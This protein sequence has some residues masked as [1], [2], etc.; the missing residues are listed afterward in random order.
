MHHLIGIS[1]MMDA[2]E[3]VP[4]LGLG[5]VST[6]TK[7]INK[8]KKYIVSCFEGW[9]KQMFLNHNLISRIPQTVR[10]LGVK[11]PFY[12]VHL[13]ITI[14]EYKY[15]LGRYTH[16]LVLKELLRVFSCDSSSRNGFVRQSVSTLVRQYVSPFY[17]LK[18]FKLT[19]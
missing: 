5:V 12:R 11:A 3:I 13:R 18:S 9:D 2:F 10:F 16:I 8:D 7:C 6:H 19:L 1:V 15:S 14:K 17:S 4:T